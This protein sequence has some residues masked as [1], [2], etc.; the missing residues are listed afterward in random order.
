MKNV[1]NELRKIVDTF[2]EKI[3]AMPDS[4]FSAKPFPNKWSKKEVLGHL[5]DSSQ[6]NLRRFICGQYEAEPP[7][8]SY[9]QD[10][11]VASNNYQAMSKS[12][13]ILLWRLMNHRICEVL[14]NMPPDNYLKE[15]DTG[16]L[17]SLGWLAEDYNKHLKHHLN[18]II[19]ASF[20]IHYT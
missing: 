8:I 16:T 5:I 10:F 18:Q 7:K 1:V 15:C 2:A 14:S 11:W 3:T 4:E 6:N 19:P 13:V 17:R 12:E 20:D 9:Q